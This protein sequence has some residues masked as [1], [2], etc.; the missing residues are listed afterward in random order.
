M[1]DA[2]LTE[3]DVLE[4]RRSTQSNLA[5]AAAYN[6]SPSTIAHIRSGRTRRGD[7]A[8]VWVRDPEEAACDMALRNFRCVEPAN[9]PL[10]WRVA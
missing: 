3:H 7:D 6:V 2:K 5:L 8:P 10:M 4:I 1:K 9:E